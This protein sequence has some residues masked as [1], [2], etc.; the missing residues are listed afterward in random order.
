MDLEKPTYP[1]E[2]VAERLRDLPRFLPS[3]SQFLYRFARHIADRLTPDHVPSRSV[4]GCCF[5]DTGLRAFLDIRFRESD[6][7][8]RTVY[9]Y[10]IPRKLLGHSM[11]AYFSLYNRLPE[12]FLAVTDGQLRV[13]TE[14]EINRLKTAFPE[15][16]DI[17]DKDRT[18]YKRHRDG[19]VFRADQ[20]QF[21]DFPSS[22]V[23]EIE[24]LEEMPPLLFSRD[25][26]SPPW[27]PAAFFVP[28]E[29]T[30]GFVPCVAWANP[31]EA[32]A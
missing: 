10:T 12:V 11:A 25:V 5:I 28:L 1:V 15:R 31:V 29:R 27:E 3:Q 21:V 8:V 7:D 14:A 23:P 9:G 26:I 19:K 16:L 20:L 18:Q 2:P 22:I 6:E 13:E 24:E 17:L 30:P 32:A 4:Y